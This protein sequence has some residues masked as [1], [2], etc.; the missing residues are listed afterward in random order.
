M[1][2]PI[3]TNLKNFSH[4][5]IDLFDKVLMRLYLNYYQPN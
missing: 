4:L 2:T 5:Y 3:E 1:K